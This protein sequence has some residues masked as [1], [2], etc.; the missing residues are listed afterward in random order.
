LDEIALENPSEAPIVET[1]PE[2]SSLEEVRNSIIG[3]E[4]F[5]WKNSEGRAYLVCGT[6]GNRQSLFMESECGPNT[7]FFEL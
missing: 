4:A 1:E 5:P 2:H 6:F 7:H 3:H